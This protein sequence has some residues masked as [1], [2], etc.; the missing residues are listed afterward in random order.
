MAP[1]TDATART[2]VLLDRLRDGDASAGSE[3]F[4]RLYGELKSIASRQLRRESPSGTLHATALVHEAWLRLFDGPAPGSYRSRLHFCS[5]AA[6][7]MRCALVDHVRE[8][9]AEK[10]GG[11]RAILSLDHGGGIDVRDEPASGTFDV[12]L[13]NEALDRLATQDAELSEIVELRVFAGLSNAEIAALR[14]QSLATIERRFALARAWLHREMIAT[15][16]AAGDGD[17][18]AGSSG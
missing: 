16:D 9:R 12:L 17:G 1:M 13:V 14:E 6:K 2:Q 10:R 7:A 3:L 4:A 5:C 8:R 15:G 11:G 18:A